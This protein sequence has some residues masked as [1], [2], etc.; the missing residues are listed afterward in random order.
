[1]KSKAPTTFFSFYDSD[2]LQGENKHRNTV[3]LIVL[4][5]SKQ[6][7]PI[8]DLIQGNKQTNV[9][10]F[11]RWENENVCNEKGGEVRKDKEKKMKKERKGWKKK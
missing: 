6:T 8:D 4:L 3:L 11:H 9:I 5:L 7:L 2:K 1:M 10:S